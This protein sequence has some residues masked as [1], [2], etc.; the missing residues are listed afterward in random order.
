MFI[1]KNKKKLARFQYRPRSFDRNSRLRPAGKRSSAAFIKKLMLPVFLILFIHFVFFSDFFRIN[2][3]KVKGSI[4]ISEDE[5]KKIVNGEIS[6]KFMGV[7]PENNY[8]IDQENAIRSALSERFPEIRAISIKKEKYKTLS[9]SID[10]KE[11]KI[12]WCRSS[13][14]YYIDSSAIAFSDASNQLQT[15]EKPLKIIE[16]PIIE[17]EMGDNNGGPALNTESMAKAKID[18]EADVDESKASEGNGQ[19]KESSVAE[20]I[21]IGEKLSDEDFIGF[22]IKLDKEISAKTGLKIKFYKTKGTKTREIIA[23]TD[24]NIRLYFNTT[25]DPSSQVYYLSEILSNSIE[26]GR[27]NDLKYIYLESEN[28]VYY[29]F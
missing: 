13:D 26:K 7:I 3:I 16:E 10:E 17:E 15:E 22:A 19:E 20:P 2:E 5:I 29:K 11:S 4:N 6:K 1:N 25:N 12:I 21:K 9:I 23:F 18:S 14:C 27:E 28:K 24:K 8:F